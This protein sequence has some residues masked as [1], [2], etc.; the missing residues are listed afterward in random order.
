[1]PD[2]DQKYL[3]SALTLLGFDIINVVLGWP[4]D[5]FGAS[6][7]GA[8]AFLFYEATK[9]KPV[10]R[11]KEQKVYCVLIGIF[12]GSLLATITSKI[13]AKWLDI[14]EVD[15]PYVYAGLWSAVSYRFYAGWQKRLPKTV[16]KLIDKAEKLTD[17]DDDTE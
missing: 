15:T 10:K 9:E 14:P 17:T 16:D 1:M 5:L 12:F 8:L 4:W 3:Y 2:R 6:F 13:A 11:T 7:A